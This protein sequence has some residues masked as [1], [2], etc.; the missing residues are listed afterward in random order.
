MFSPL[1]NNNEFH[2]SSRTPINH[3]N[4]STLKPFVY[5]PGV[6][7]I[8][9][10]AAALTEQNLHNLHHPPTIN[11]IKMNIKKNEFSFSNIL[12]EAGSKVK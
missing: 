6:T 3:K 9:T 8:D 5:V 11:N 1:K 7:K 2:N 4:E 12:L 10:F